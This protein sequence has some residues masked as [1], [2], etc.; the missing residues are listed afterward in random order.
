VHTCYGLTMG[1]VVPNRYKIASMS[2]VTLPCI[3]SVGFGAYIALKLINDGPGWRWIYYIYLILMSVATIFQYLFYNPP[4]F[5][6]LHGGKRTVW[7]EVKRI[8]F[9]GTFLLTTGV[10]MF[11][12]GISW[13]GQPAPWSS[14]KILSLII[15]GI[16]CLVAFVFWE[17]YARIPNPV[18]PM[19]FFKDV[20]GFSC[21]AVI[22][23]VSGSAYVGPTII[24]PSQVANIYGVG[25][26]DWKEN[27][28][29]SCTV[30]FG[31]IGGIWLWG[32]LI[33]ILKRVKYQLVVMSC[34]VCAFSGALASANRDNKVQSALFSF[35]ATFPDGIMELTPLGL[36][37]MSANDAD[38]G[39]VF[40]T[41]SFLL[42][43]RPTSSPNPM[44]KR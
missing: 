11:L 32:P 18:V 10:M 38:L 13:G 25:A 4:T 37:Q 1:E 19:Y 12:L 22:A 17:I 36:V 15:I 28:W 24:W 9:V 2:L 7:Q 5:Q 31:I 30:A 20:R 27:A 21:L 29:L 23:S 42:F 44:T 8:D 39:T 41:S 14:A 6:Q 35:F 34:L 26:T 40:G 16:L 3:V 33:G 43:F